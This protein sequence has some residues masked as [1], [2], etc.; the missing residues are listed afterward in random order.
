MGAKP[1]VVSGDVFILLEEWATQK[2][3]FLPTRAFFQQLRGEFITYM[4][5][6]F[7][8]FEFVPEDELSL[9][10]K[11]LVDKSGLLPVSIDRVYYRS[12][13]SLEL[14]RLVDKRGKDRG[15]GRRVG[16]PSLFK[17]FS[18][19]RSLSNRKIVL[20]DDVIFTGE[21]LEKVCRILS[22]LGVQ[23]PL[24]CAGI[25]IGEGIRRL[26]AQG[27][28]IHCVRSYE[29]VIDEICERDFY[30]GVPLSGRTLIGMVNTGVPYLLPFGNPGKW[31]SIPKKWRVP[32]SQFCI[33]QTIKLFEAIEQRSN[34]PIRC[35]DLG[36]GVVSIPADETRYVDAL[37]NVLK[38][39]DA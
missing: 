17:Q 18:N 1:Y 14:T 6:V 21:L 39:A 37:E 34:R 31:A 26:K 30:P 27:V 35:L 11:G 33:R 29:D 8:S 13:T 9:G 25:G 19:L 22:K 4:Q 23:V 16:T 36:R 10:L 20:V 12:D 24:I 2:G 28:E 5:Q 15:L 38:S 32:L 3:L 7:E